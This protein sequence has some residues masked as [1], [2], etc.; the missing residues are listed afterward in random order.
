MGP[1]LG[2]DFRFQV[3]VRVSSSGLRVGLVVGLGL[4]LGLRSGSGL[5]LMLGLGLDPSC[6]QYGSSSGYAGGGV[7]RKDSAS[8]FIGPKTRRQIDG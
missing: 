4:V 3:R 2:Y 5:G 7:G 8:S 6:T 1:V